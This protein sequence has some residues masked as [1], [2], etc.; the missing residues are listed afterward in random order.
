MNLK[1]GRTYLAF[2]IGDSRAV[3]AT[4][5]A[6]LPGG[7]IVTDIVLNRLAHPLLVHVAHG[8]SQFHLVL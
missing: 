2:L 8:L 3:Q 7:Y 5:H 4:D 6:A 1:I